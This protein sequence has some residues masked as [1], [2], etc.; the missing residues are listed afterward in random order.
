MEALLVADDVQAHAQSVARDDLHSILRAGENA[1]IGV[2][3]EHG[4]VDDHGGM[5]AQRADVAD[6]FLRAI[7]P[8]SARHRLADPT[9]SPGFGDETAAGR[10]I[11]GLG[12]VP[13]AVTT[14]GRT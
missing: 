14:L 11:I 13:V 5:R 9:T 4:I 3:A 6:I 1:A 2:I 7:V 10:S 8:G 12:R